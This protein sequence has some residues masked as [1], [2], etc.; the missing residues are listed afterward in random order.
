MITK[1]CQPN[2]LSIKV[3]SAKIVGNETSI[4]NNVYKIFEWVH[5]NTSYCDICIIICDMALH[6]V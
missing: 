6:V 4:Y 2:D 3:V 1:N 5:I